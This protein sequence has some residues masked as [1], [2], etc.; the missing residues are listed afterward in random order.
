VSSFTE[1]HADVVLGELTMFD[2]MIFKGHLTRLFPDGAF[3]RFLR[4]QEVLLKDFGRYVKRATDALKAHAQGTC[5]QAGRPYRYLPE[6]TTRARSG[7]SKEDIAR[8]IAD[9]DAISE[10]LVC[11]L[12]TVEPCVSFDVVGN[13][14]THRLQIVRRARKCLHL[15]WYFIDPEFGFCH[16]R[17]QS[18]F[19]FEIQVYVNG[20]EWLARQ[21][22]VRGISVTRHD[23]ALL[24]IEDLEVAG[25]LCDRFAHRAWPRV[26]NAFAARVNPHLRTIRQA[27]FGGY[28]WVIDQAEVATDVMFATRPALERI[29]SDLVTHA[30]TAFGAEDV[31]RFLGR[32][33]NGNLAKAVETS[34]RR[35]PEGWRVKHRLGRNSIKV[36][37]KASVLRV[38]TTINNPSEFRVLRRVE[39]DGRR[40]LRWCDMNKGVANTWRYYQVGAQANHRYLDALGAVQ[41]K[42]EAIAAIEGLCRSRVRDRRRHGR[43]NPL[44]APD[45]DLFRAVLA[46]EHAIRGFRNRDLTRRLY[47]RPPGSADEHRRRCQRTSRLIA[48]LR[49]H[50][51]V[52]KVP[53]Q[54]LY[55]PTRHGLRVMTAVLHV[56]DHALPQAFLA[57]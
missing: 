24:R 21:L 10:G 31:L 53:H 54:R 49:G 19:P 45:L 42:G 18:W 17:V 47:P 37:D 51:L 35:R 20:R 55:R 41:P 12:A 57:T 44:T 4:S 43:F 25:Q 11:V 56:H 1:A 30:A 29:Y 2:R 48:K 5:E 7:I 38:E 13:A 3:G 22:A 50:G 14:A 9:A 40:S 32:K 23:N 34:T 15:Y 36:Y 46:G 6:A 33:L 39:T 16:V 28:Y 27:G 52:A 26:L 8:R